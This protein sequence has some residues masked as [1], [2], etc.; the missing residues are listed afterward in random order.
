MQMHVQANMTS[1]GLD[2]LVNYQL[3]RI[4]QS[5]RRKKIAV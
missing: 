5:Q 1:L 2:F 4:V 3:K